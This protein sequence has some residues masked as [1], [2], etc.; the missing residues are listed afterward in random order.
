MYQAQAYDQF[1]ATT[2]LA[3]IKAMSQN[4]PKLQE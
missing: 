2:K 1:L 3:T 4:P